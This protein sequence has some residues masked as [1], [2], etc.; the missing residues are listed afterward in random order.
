MEGTALFRKENITMETYVVER[1][2]IGAVGADF[3]IMGA[4][5]ARLGSWPHRVTGGAIA[6]FGAAMVLVALM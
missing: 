5:G 3:F 1:I 2:L 4:L 6:A